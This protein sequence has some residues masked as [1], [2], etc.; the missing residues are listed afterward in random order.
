MDAVAPARPV[1][2]GAGSSA[3][4]MKESPRGF[5]ARCVTVLIILSPLVSVM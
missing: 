2:T 5:S 1:Q 3:N 4:K